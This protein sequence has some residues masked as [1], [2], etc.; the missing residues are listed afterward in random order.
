MVLNFGHRAEEY[1][2]RP[3]FLHSV[4]L[5]RHE[6]SLTK[7]HVQRNRTDLITTEVFNFNPHFVFGGN[8]LPGIKLVHFNIRNSEA[9]S[10]KQPK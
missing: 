5:T 3:I 7:A 6:A 8:K 4:A 2:S 10:K 9:R 1:K